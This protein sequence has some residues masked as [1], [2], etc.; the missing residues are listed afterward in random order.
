M[1]EL[2]AD[3]SSVTQDYLKAVWAAS[4]WG[5]EGASI[6]GLARRMGVAP[7]TASENVARL[8]EAG[9]LEHAPYRAVTLSAQGQ[10]LARG[11]VRRH[12]LLETYLVAALGFEWDEVHAEAEVLEHAV[13][14]RLL[15]AL[16]AALGHPARDPHGDPIPTADGRVAVPDLC[17]VDSLRVGQCGVVGRIRD[18]SDVLKQLAQAGIGLDTR[19]L[20][21]GRGGDADPRVTS[22]R[23]VRSDGAAA[24]GEGPIAVV[25]AG[26]LW[27]LAPPD[28]AQ[29]PQ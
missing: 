22:V 29:A 16:D 2:T 11:M 24:A 14:D 15:A 27:V 10:R 7:S 3:G 9:L 5:G 26:C 6:T 4:E 19:V 21:V 18:D 20:V 17:A 28:A 25:P 13:S 8:V 12:R 1:R 23:A